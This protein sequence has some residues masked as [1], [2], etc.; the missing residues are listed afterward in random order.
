MAMRMPHSWRA[1][2]L[3]VVDDVL[4]EKKNSSPKQS[5][6]VKGLKPYRSTFAISVVDRPVRKCVKCNKDHFLNQCVKFR[7]LSYED[8][9]EFVRNRN[10]CFSCLEPGHWSKDCKQTKP[11]KVEGC[12]RRH[13]TVL[14][15]PA[16]T[17]I[18]H[19]GT[20]GDESPVLKN[21]GSQ[22]PETE[23]KFNA[24]VNTS[25]NEKILLNVIPVKVRVNGDKNAIVTNAFFD[26]GS[27]CSFISES[28]MHKLN[29]DG[30]KINL[31]VRTINNETESKQSIIVK[32]LEISDFDESEYVPLTPLFS[33]DK[34]GVEQ[35]D[36]PSQKDVDQFIEFKNVV[37]PNIKS[38][39][40]LLIGKDNPKLHKPLEVAYGPHDYFASE[41]VGWISCPPKKNDNQGNPCNYFVK[42]E[43]HPLWQMCTDFIDSAN[44][45]KEEISPRQQM[46]LDRVSE[47]IKLKDD[48]H[49]EIDLPFIN[50]NSKL[51][52]NYL[53]VK[54]RTES[55]KRRFI[56]DPNF[57]SEY[58]DFV[59][60]MLTM[61]YAEE[62][63][64]STESEGQIWYINHHGVYHPEKKKIRVV[65]DCSSKFQG[66]CL[67]DVLLQ[68]P[69]L[70]NNLVGVLSRFRKN[71]VAVQGDIR[72]M[73]LQVKVP[74]KHRN[75]LRFFWWE[76]S[77]INK[78]MKEFRMTAYP[79]GTVCSPSC[80]NYALKQ[81]A[82][83]NKHDF[84]I[85]VINAINDSFYVD[86]FFDSRPNAESA[87]S[88]VKNISAVCA[89]GGFEVLKWIS[90]NRN[91][92][93]EIPEDMRSK[94]L[95]NLNLAVDALPLEH[96][97]GM[98]W[99]V[100]ED[101]LCFSVNPKER[102]CNRRGMLSVVNSIFDPMG[103]V[104]PV[105]QPVKVLMQMLCRQ[106]FSWDDP[107]PPGVE[108]EWLKWLSELPKLKEFNVPRCF[109]PVDYGE[110][111]E[112]QIHHFSDASEKSYGAVS[113]LR[114]LNSSGQI[115]CVLLCGKSRLV[116]LKGSTIPRLELCAATISARTDKFFRN[117]LKIE[118]LASYFWTDSTTVL[119]YLANEDKV[120][121]T[122]VANRVNLIK[123][124][125]EINQWYYVPSKLNPADVASR[126][127]SV[128][129]FLNY[130]EWKSGPSF[131]WK[132]HDEW[133][134]QPDF[135]HSVSD[136]NLEIKKELP[137]KCFAAVK[138]Q[139]CVLDDVVA[140]YSNWYHLK[141]IIAWMLRY[142]NKLKLIVGSNCN[143][144]SGPV[145]SLTVEEMILAEVEIIKHEQ[146]KY[147]L[148]EID[149]LFKGKQIPK[150]SSLCN[151]QPFLENGLLCV[152]GRIRAANV[153]FNAKHPI[154]IPKESKIA[155]LIIDYVH[156][157]TG[158]N[159]RE[160]LLA[161]INQKYWIV[162]GNALV[163]SV[164]RGCVPCRK[165]QR[166]PE[167]QLMADLPENRLIPDKPPFT[168]VAVDCFGPFLIKQGRSEVKR[169]GVLFTCLVSRA[170]HVEI[171]NSLDTSAFIMSLRRFIA[172]RGQVIEMRSDNGTNFP[173]GERELRDAIKSWNKNQIHDY[174]LQKN[175]KWIF[176]TPA[177][178]H[179]GGVFERQIRTIRKI[180]NAICC[181]QV[182]TDESLRTLMCECE[183]IVNER[184]ITTVSNDPKDLTP[185]SPNNLLLMK[186]EPMLPPGVF[187]PKDMYARKRWKQ[188]QYLAD[189][190]W[191]RWRKEFLPLLQCRQKWNKVQRDLQKDDIVLV[192]N[193]NQ[194]RNTWLLGRVIE[195][196]QDSKGRVR[197]VGV[198]TKYS[199]FQRPVT[200]LVLLRECD[201]A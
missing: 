16:K 125:S 185:L 73:F 130:P 97:L 187:D 167:S 138:D 168:Y 174:L 144:K 86:D 107:I 34:I 118:I 173:S 67:N 110:V 49:Y 113:Y 153:E 10:L 152:G 57:Y 145:E 141:K 198:Q 64:D 85:S 157:T 115:H 193:E 94:N 98:I 161:E 30:L 195:T 178:S 136:G 91:V 18:N 61:G 35:S 31:N 108:Q 201:E 75:Y 45:E 151:L 71:V 147:I 59:E 2:W 66:I 79:F 188:V 44:N 46:F 22:T 139:P 84:D 169:Y 3:S 114:M 143:L 149:V 28:L 69:D 50:P 93:A 117:E 155:S 131:L 189:V 128:D 32:G 96:A 133:P 103:L 36:I 25:K 33:N 80:C 177:S 27:T 39:V 83:D 132:C 41:T 105:L 68:G 129:A 109:V 106:K 65:F 158:H 70:A 159:G 81:S 194:P 176:Q 162:K 58:K 26:N 191:K 179:H 154:I 186:E 48:G 82:E 42:N 199:I 56:R 76:D 87:V 99:S 102:P 171:A 37:I 77:D 1:G 72:S 163:R 120:F 140:K 180:F 5:N 172:R 164:L 89:K 134:E 90:N 127:M 192:V 63:S 9:I 184:P 92:I 21:F 181:E 126:V 95:K 24:F 122:F 170:V 52:S 135:L 14:H 146:R 55:L 142:I 54:Q 182:L 20:K 40:G 8:K 53:Q 38:E 112:T 121:K 137:E 60:N 200:K 23:T 165:R 13:T 29:V 190:F 150:S 51:P 196:Y 19:S 148:K 12:K 123:E 43:V 47:S 17:Q 7:E 62:V 175:I 104:Q 183:N 11:C 100:D 156:R 160:Y 197:S 15:P 166:P 6:P 116:P 111:V 74:E 4:N 119:R 88:L 124:V 78:P 101:I